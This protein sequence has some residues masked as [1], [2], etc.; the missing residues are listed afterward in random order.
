MA[1][2]AKASQAPAPDGA[3][4]GEGE[5]VRASRDS[6]NAHASQGLDYPRQQLAL[7]V[8]VA[9]IAHTSIAP[10]PDAAAGGECEAVFASSRDSDDVQASK[11]VDLLRQYLV[12]HVAV[13]QPA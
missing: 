5:V 9:E 12:L 3:V 4:G 1:Q 2:L 13:A 11:G 8:A 6:D 7:L 10:A